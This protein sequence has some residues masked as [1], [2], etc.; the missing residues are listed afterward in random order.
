M[1]QNSSGEI[2]NKELLEKLT[3]ILDEHIPHL[4]EV[5]VYRL[6]QKPYDYYVRYILLQL[7][8]ERSFRPPPST[9]RE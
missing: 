4:G 6:T 8:T 3:F 5:K 2:S 7:G 9:S 1:G